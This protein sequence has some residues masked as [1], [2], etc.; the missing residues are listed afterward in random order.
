MHLHG[1]RIPLQLRE[2]LFATACFQLHTRTNLR[3]LSQ[4]CISG[5]SESNA[6][7]FVVSQLPQLLSDNDI[8]VRHCWEGSRG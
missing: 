8:R 7:Y 3:K 6:F 1:S 4:A 5:C 2:H